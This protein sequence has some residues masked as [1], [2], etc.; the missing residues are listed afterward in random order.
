MD[1]TSASFFRPGTVPYIL[2]EAFYS[3]GFSILSKNLKSAYKV[4]VES[5]LNATNAVLER[6]R[7]S[8]LFVE[9]SG[10]DVCLKGFCLE[11]DPH[12]FRETFLGWVELQ[13]RRKR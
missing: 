12:E 3:I 5:T 6:G 7:D 2:A 4:L 8:V 10:L 9:G 11:V 13:K 1:T